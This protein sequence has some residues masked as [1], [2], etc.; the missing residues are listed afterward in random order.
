MFVVLYHGGK[1]F[2]VFGR[3][4]SAIIAPLNKINNF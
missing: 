4:G 3:T 2:V 1:L